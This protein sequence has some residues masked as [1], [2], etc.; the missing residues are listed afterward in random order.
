M[1][2]PVKRGRVA[3]TTLNQPDSTDF[4]SMESQRFLPTPEN[5]SMP[6]ILLY[7]VQNHCETSDAWFGSDFH[8]DMVE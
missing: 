4:L 5:N 7:R 6:V 3:P 8:L 2:T 1:K